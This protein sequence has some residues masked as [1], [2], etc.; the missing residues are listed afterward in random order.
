M[1]CESVP[2]RPLESAAAKEFHGKSH[3][4]RQHGTLEIN[5]SLWNNLLLDSKG[6]DMARLPQD[7]SW[8]LGAPVILRC[9]IGVPWVPPGS[10]GS[11]G[12]PFGAR[13]LGG[14][15]GPPGAPGG[16]LENTLGG[17]HGV[18]QGPRGS[19]GLA[20]GFLGSPGVPWAPRGPR[21]AAVVFVIFFWSRRKKIWPKLSKHARATALTISAPGFDN[22]RAW[23]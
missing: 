20:W 21:H 10:P 11:P 19:P 1:R 22:F 7:M 3:M 16:S 17:S 18:P 9:S 12:V 14:N 5:K 8:G 23:L 4:K 15:R 6:R 2:F 13:P